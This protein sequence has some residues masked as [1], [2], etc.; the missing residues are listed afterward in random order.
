MNEVLEIIKNIDGMSEDIAQAIIRYYNGILHE[1][2]QN[3]IVKANLL[4]QIKNNFTV[5]RYL[6]L[7][8]NISGCVSSLSSCITLSENLEDWNYINTFLH[9]LTHQIAKN[10]FVDPEELMVLQFNCG[11]KMSFDD[12]AASF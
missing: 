9:E 2:N 5:I 4:N 1:F 10:E 12:L 6:S 8:D 3:P 7:S 11:L